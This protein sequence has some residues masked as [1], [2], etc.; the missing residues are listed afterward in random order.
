MAFCSDGT[1]AVTRGKGTRAGLVE[2][3]YKASAVRAGR[4]FYRIARSAYYRARFREACFSGA[5][6]GARKRAHERTRP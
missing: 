4:T 3:L 1:R 2:P 5:R 6:L